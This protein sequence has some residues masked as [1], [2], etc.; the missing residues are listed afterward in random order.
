VRSLSVVVLGGGVAGLSASLA[1]ARAGHHVTIIERDDLAPSG[2]LD[3]LHRVRGGI[4]HFLQPHAFIP[5]ARKEMRELFPDV[6]RSLL[7]AGAWELDLRP[8]IP[9]VVVEEDEELAYVGVRRP[10]IEWALLRAVHAE[11][12]ITVR[13][14][15][16]VTGL[17]ADGSSPTRIRGAV[18]TAGRVTG[19]LVVDALGRRSPVSAWLLA[20]GVS[21]REERSTEC[22]II[23][24]SRYYRVRDGRTL[25]A[26][27]GVPSPRGDLGYGSFATFPG[28]NGTFAGI[29][30]IPPGDQELKAL[31][32]PAAFEAAAAT[33]PALHAWTNRDV[34]EPITGVLAMG[35]LQNT[36]RGPFSA[37]A[38]PVGMVSVGDA[39]C[40]TD[41]VMALGVAFAL[42]HARALTSALDASATD[43]VAIA[44]AF[45]RATRPAMEERFGYASAIDDARTRLW[46]NQPVDYAHRSAGFYPFFTFAAGAAAA[47][48]DPAVFRAVVRRNTFLDPLSVLDADVPLQD[49]IETV[50]ADLL[51]RGRPRPG[52]ARDELVRLV[53]AAVPDGA[54]VPAV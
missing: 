49:R 20:H 15:V 40:H 14:G 27:P 39:V 16:R 33:M 19:D 52:P 54:G 25:P 4:P 29:I 35:S 24:Y 1:L 50:F 26:G 31:K 48:V 11:P 2:P 10:L 38:G 6:Y 22:G 30:A 47:L 17:D 44:A 46:T 23:Y 21:P 41:P 18:T 42:I 5:R 28:D 12:S 37:D 32:H 13:G 34:A 43:P 9:G 51:A 7:D 8:R 53:Q 36:L 3:A 45:E